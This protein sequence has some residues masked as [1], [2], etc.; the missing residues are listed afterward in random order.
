MQDFIEF[1]NLGPSLWI[2]MLWDASVWSAH[3][4][5]ICFQKYC[6]TSWAATFRR[7]KDLCIRHSFRHNQRSTP[8]PVSVM[9]F[10][11][12]YYFRADILL[13][14]IFMA[15]KR[16]FGMLMN[17]HYFIMYQLNLLGV[18]PQLKFFLFIWSKLFKLHHI[19]NNSETFLF[20]K[21]FLFSITNKFYFNKM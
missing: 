5:V 6:L 4:W 21:S 12:W 16:E 7:I 11:G 15:K 3:L 1:N 9:L 14:K 18:H 13:T 20:Y 17:L 19:L 2:A 8:K 10:S